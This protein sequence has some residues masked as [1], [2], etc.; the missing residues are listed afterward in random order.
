MSERK[1][2]AKFD[3]VDSS[4]GSNNHIKNILASVSNKSKHNIADF[5]RLSNLFKRKG[6]Q[7]DKPPKVIVVIQLC[8]RAYRV[9][10]LK[11]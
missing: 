5:S 4:S 3:S 11:I 7:A 10:L 8:I 6:R 1:N 9:F 2:K